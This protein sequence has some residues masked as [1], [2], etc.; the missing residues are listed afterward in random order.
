[1][2]PADRRFFNPDVSDRVAVV[3]VQPHPIEPELYVVAAARGPSQ[4]QLAKLTRYGPY[5]ATELA[6]P[7]AQVCA[8]LIDEGYMPA[9]CYAISA[10]LASKDAQQV[11]LAALRF[12]WRKADY[13]VPLLLAKLD[14]A[15]TE[16]C[17]LLD[18]LGMIGDPSAIP[19]VRKWASDQ[20]WFVQRSAV[21]ALR[22]LGDVEGLAQC[23][24][25]TRKLLPKPVQALLE[26]GEKPDLAEELA[27]A[28]QKLD[29]SSA[30][31]TMD[32]LYEIGT[33]SCVA[34]VHR[35]LRQLPINQAHLWRYAKSVHK[36]A[37]LRGDAWTFG[38][39]AY[40]I[41][42]RGR[43]LPP[44]WMKVPWGLVNKKKSVRIFAKQTRDYLRRAA[45]RF[46]RFVARHRP[47]A[48]AHLAAECLIHYTPEDYSQ[49]HGA[50]GALAE[51]YLLNRILFM[52]GSRIA[53]DRRLRAVFVGS[54]TTPPSGVREEMYP[55]LW[56]RQPR[57]FLRVLTQAKLPEVHP[58]AVR[59]LR[60]DHPEILREAALHDVLLLIDAPYEP[61]V[62]LGLYEL[63]RR[64]D[65]AAPD[66]ELL[67][68]VVGDSR[69]VVRGLG[70]RWLSESAAR[71]LTDGALTVRLLML[72]DA[73]MAGYVAELAVAQLPEDAALRRELA[74]RLLA[75]LRLP[76][77][78]PGSHDAPGRLARA[79]LV[80]YL[81]GKLTV[82]ELVRLVLTGSS[83]MQALAGLLLAQTAG[84]IAELGLDQ[85]AVLAQHPLVGVR[86]ATHKLLREAEAA[87]QAEPAIL[88]VL[89]ESEWDD[90]RAL[91]MEMLQRLDWPKL[92]LEGLGGLL[93]SNRVD[94]QNLG[95]DLVLQYFE[96]V[97]TSELVERLVQHPHPNMRRF[98]LELVLQ[99]SPEGHR[100]LVRLGQFFRAILFDLWPTRAD[101]RRVL[102]FLQMRGLRSPEEALAVADVLNAAVRMQSREDFERAL[103]TLARL[104][105]AW[106]EVDL[107]V[108]LAPEAVR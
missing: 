87:L 81:L 31:L 33:P 92:G 1:M 77:D 10:Q 76:E 86:R 47:D 78:P 9:G 45:W 96:L 16:H 37:K 102:E 95:R 32:R 38:L 40:L 57:A 73:A 50:A 25:A 59:A 54:Q 104:K 12:G 74:E 34:A 98:A 69:E 35:L 79:L 21:E 51:C 8:Q 18:A 49:P 93:D 43:Q 20:R 107:G 105:L 103:A 39:S 90:T 71:W 58:F 70:R 46:L 23:L 60:D 100:W 72:P 14:K 64:F 88:F 17:A 94:V 66:W 68:R 3:S 108:S 85:L 52:G 82:V 22:N 19:A 61:T 27:A 30:G 62:E 97:P 53:F 65:R 99:H 56:D 55:Q 48:Y 91:A 89:V 15:K 84:V 42:S 67:S 5:A 80:P 44:I 13:A 28:V 26:V 106:P 4:R 2:L 75:I 29:T 6:G 63:D 83:A 7:F 36:R 101:K 11:A 24:A 41:E